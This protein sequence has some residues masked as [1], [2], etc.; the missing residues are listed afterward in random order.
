MV[1]G[2]KVTGTHQ[3]EISL[4]RLVV[5]EG[6]RGKGYAKLLIDT[7]IE[8]A[9]DFLSTTSA[10]QSTSGSSRRGTEITLSGQTYLKRF[11]E[12][13]GFVAEGDV[14]EEDGIPHQLFRYVNSDT[15][16]NKFNDR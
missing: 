10:S 4:G 1:L 6:V 2:G 13:R 12:E 11:Y 5:R 7:G 16:D 14:Y 8:K 15:P 3:S 9:Q